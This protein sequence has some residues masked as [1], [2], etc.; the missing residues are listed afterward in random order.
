ME[1]AA[2]HAKD[3]R[4]GETQS[5]AEGFGREDKG[6]RQSR[7]PERGEIGS[8]QRLTSAVAWYNTRHGE[9]EV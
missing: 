2:G 7:A 6:P 1:R 9:E 4:S 5:A 3:C 8:V